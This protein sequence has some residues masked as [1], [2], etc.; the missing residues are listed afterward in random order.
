MDHLIVGA[1]EVGR[2]LAA[3]LECDLRD[4]DPGNTAGR[5]YDVLHVAFPWSGAFTT[6]VD[7][8]VTE[9]SAE[10]VVVHSTVPP[11]ICDTYGW[12]HSPVRGRHPHL[13]EG[14]RVF[15]KHFGGVHAREMAKPFV[16]RGI[17]TR[18]HASAAIT[19]AGKL[20]ELATLGISVR[21][22][23]EIAS[24]CERHG[25]PFEEVYRE[26][27]ESYND[28]YRQLGHPQF[29]QPVLD[30]VP[31]PLGG[32]CVAQNAPLLDSPFVNTLLARLTPESLA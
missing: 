15:V 25:L 7:D 32:H 10:H 12:T 6:T 17:E 5:R 30:Y 16:D 11:G 23:H 19:E 20:W 13:E 14:I 4:I 9:H 29:T 22:N 8:Y 3:V 18:C 28:G 31:G 27:R 21:V 26:F 2:A 24:Y 1:G